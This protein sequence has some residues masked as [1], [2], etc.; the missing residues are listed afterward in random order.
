MVPEISSCGCI[1]A[2]DMPERGGCHQG[3]H[4]CIATELICWNL[5]FLAA[6]GRRRFNRESVANSI[7]DLSPEVVSL[8]ANVEKWL[9]RHNYIQLGTRPLLVATVASTITKNTVYL[10]PIGI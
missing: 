8:Y 9:C 3:S 5:F 10:A 7:M 6:A 1:Y 4:S 2:N